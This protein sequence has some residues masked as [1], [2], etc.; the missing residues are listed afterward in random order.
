MNLDG[1]KPD[2]KQQCRPPLQP[3]ARLKSAAIFFHLFPAHAFLLLKFYKIGF[4]ASHWPLLIPFH[5]VD[6]GMMLA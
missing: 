1:N 2:A 4:N 3:A 6:F 5:R